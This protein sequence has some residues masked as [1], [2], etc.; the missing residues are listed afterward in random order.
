MKVSWQQSL[1]F[2]GTVAHLMTFPFSPYAHCH[3]LLGGLCA[4]FF[5]RWVPI[6]SR[7]GFNPDQEVPLIFSA[8]LG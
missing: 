4:A 2:T 5:F 7:A 1:Y 8:C 3:S 6:V